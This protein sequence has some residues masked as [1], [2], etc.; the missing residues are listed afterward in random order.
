MSLFEII[1]LA[2]LGAAAWLWLDSLKTREIGVSTART[3]CAA[4]G[5]QFLDDSVA[6]ESLW[7]VRDDEGQLKL[8]RVY[9]FE[10]SD[11]GNNRCKGSVTMIGQQVVTFYVGPRLV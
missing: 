8:R 2:L 6:I 10:Y 7:P 5:L 1:G 3:A 4:D 9:S 11:T